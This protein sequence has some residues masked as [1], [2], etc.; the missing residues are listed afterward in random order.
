MAIDYLFLVPSIYFCSFLAPRTST[1]PHS[2][3][4]C[5]CWYTHLLVRV[6]VIVSP[7]YSSTQTELGVC[8]V[9]CWHPWM[10]VFLCTARA[11]T[12]PHGEKPGRG[13]R[14]MGHCLGPCRHMHIYMHMHTFS[15]SSP[16]LSATLPA[17]SKLQSKQSTDNMLASKYTGH[18][19]TSS[20]SLGSLQAVP[21]L[22]P[23]HYWNVYSKANEKVFCQQ[24]Q[25]HL[26]VRSGSRLIV[27][28]GNTITFKQWIHLF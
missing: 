24:A 21:T 25:T 6:H 27:L 14:H 12:Y 9:Q 11:T 13:C 4:V 17:A 28:Q 2:F 18:L 22:W 1:S 3:S 5:V 10:W 7:R 20:A 8:M 26:L 23:S 16:P 15:L 19:S